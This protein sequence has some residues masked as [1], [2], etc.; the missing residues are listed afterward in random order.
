MPNTFYGKKVNEE[1]ILNEEET[2]HIK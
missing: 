1:I 2:A